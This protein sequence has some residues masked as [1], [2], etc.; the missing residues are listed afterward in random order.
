MSSVTHSLISNLNCL[1][2]QKIGI[3]LLFPTDVNFPCSPVYIYGLLCGP[4]GFLG[5][6]PQKLS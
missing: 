6:E 1:L 5:L 2:N 4:F 3:F